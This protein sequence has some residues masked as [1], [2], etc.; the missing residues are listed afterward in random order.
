MLSSKIKI[1][2]RKAKISSKTI[3]PESITSNDSEAF[4]IKNKE[5]NINIRKKN[6]NSKK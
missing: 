1:K 4:L 2:G 6:K 3:L 5:S